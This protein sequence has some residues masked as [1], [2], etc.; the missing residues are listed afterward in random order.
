[1]KSTDA[2][3]KSKNFV[4]ILPKCL[5]PHEWMLK[6]SQELEGLVLWMI[7]P[8]TQLVPVISIQ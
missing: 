4:G 2:V 7:G 5:V 6:E 1:M 8:E 3:K